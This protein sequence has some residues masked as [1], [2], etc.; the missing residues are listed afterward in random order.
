[1]LC[2]VAAATSVEQD[3]LGFEPVELLRGSVYVSPVAYH[4]ATVDHPMPGHV[5]V[6]VHKG[7]ERPPHL[8][9]EPRAAQD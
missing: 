3:P 8:S 1:M 5:G 7:G 4:P 2:E 6:T 9:R